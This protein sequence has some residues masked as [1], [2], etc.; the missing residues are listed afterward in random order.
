MRKG[1]VLFTAAERRAF[2]QKSLA[3]F[4][5]W[6]VKPLRLRS[7]LARLGVEAPVLAAAAPPAPPIDLSGRRILLAEDNDINALILQKHLE[8]R[9]AK[10]TRVADGEAALA[11][12]H[13]A[14]TQARFDAVILDLR[15]PGL[16]GLTLAREIRRLESAA[17]AAPSR[18]IAVSADAFRDTEREALASGHRP[19]PDQARRF[20]PPR[21]GACR[22]AC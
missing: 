6:L 4:D 19:L 9:G 11:R 12:A 5:G 8:K 2:G 20:R 15:M 18:L 7:L 21:C 14:L 3:A 22:A 13:A 16:D 17:G 1:L 10:I